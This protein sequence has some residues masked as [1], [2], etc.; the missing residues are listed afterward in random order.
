MDNKNYIVP[1]EA[2]KLLGVHYQTLRN[3]DTQ[4]RIDTIRM[5]G[6]K[7]LYNVKK[8]IQDNNHIVVNNINVS[9]AIILTRHKICYCR[10]SS[11]NQKDDLHKQIKYMEELYPTHEIIYDIGSGINFKRKNLLKIIN[12]AITNQIEEVVIAHKDRLC[13]FGY[14]LLEMIINEHSHGIITVIN[15]DYKSLQEELTK[16]LVSIINIFSAKLNGMR[17]YKVK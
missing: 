10:V 13:S 1:K 9:S 8:Y 4:G 15:N 12:L 5:P 6:G 7:R 3:W 2:S 14:D 17:S 16:D 11:N